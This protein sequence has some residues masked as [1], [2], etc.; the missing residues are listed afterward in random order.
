MIKLKDFLNLWDGSAK[1]ALHECHYNKDGEKYIDTLLLMFHDTI[2]DAKML[3]DY[4]LNAEVTHSFVNKLDN[5]YLYIYTK[6][7][8]D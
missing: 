3:D 7:Y 4:H 2:N 1:I 8:I 6:K 5:S